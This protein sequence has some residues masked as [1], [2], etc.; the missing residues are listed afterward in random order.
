MRF[1]AVMMSSETDPRIL[2]LET[3]FCKG[4]RPLR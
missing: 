4:S 3:L 2:T 1:F